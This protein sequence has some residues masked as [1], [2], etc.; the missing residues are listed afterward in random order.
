MS[1]L[2]K[3]LIIGLVWPEPTSSAAGS[4]MLQL[5]ELFLTYGYEITFV[6]AAQKSE[7]SFD[8]TQQG[9]KIH[10]IQLNHDSFDDFIKEL[11]PTIVLYDRFVTEEQFGWRVT[12]QCPEALTILDTEDLHFLRLARQ[13][14]HK[15]GV[16]YDQLNLHTDTAKRE[17]A[18]IYRCD[19][20]L[21]ISQ[22]E[23][24]VLQN[25]FQVPAQQ[26]YYL[27]FLVDSIT[28]DITEY[29]KPFEEREDFV[30]IG[31]F[32]HEPNWDA[33]RYLKE[34]I[35]EGIRKELPNVSLHVYGA[36]ASDKVMQLHNHTKGFLVHGRAESAYGVLGNARVLLAPLRFG[37]G[38]KGKLLEAMQSGTPSVTTSIGAESMANGLAWNGV[39]VDDI[40]GYVAASID[41]YQNK[42]KWLK[43]QSN[44]VEIVNCNY[45]KFM[46]REAF[47][48]FIQDRMNQLED[49]R[50]QN[51]VGQM[52]RHHTLQSTKYLSKW[53][54]EKNKR[55]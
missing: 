50:K 18:S 2:P 43:A 24:D 6:S 47:F 29:W 42:E 45:D 33:V 51:F 53:I 36:Y 1:S 10:S 39:I 4:R 16:V 5:I 46:Y 7:H 35:W 20:S 37:A 31:N 30:F 41:L 12:E 40:E 17:I 25:Q 14:A 32:W 13:E 15:K 44:G 23:M 54:A 28:K 9:L 49:F 55:N 19:V 27:P 3:L 21:I 26:L 38:A 22:Y 11:S 48:D 34:S 8:L 52:L